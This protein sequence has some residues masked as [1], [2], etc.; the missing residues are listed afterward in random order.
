VTIGTATATANIAD[1]ETATADLSVT[2]QGNEAGPQ[3]IVYTVTLNAANNSGAP[4]TFAI[5][6][7]GGTATSG[8]DFTAFGGTISVANGSSTGTLTVT[9]LNDARLENTE[10]VQATISS[11]SLASVSIGAASA[12]AN[13]LEEGG[14]ATL[15]VTQNGVEATTPTSVV[16]TV[17]LSKTNNTGSAITFDV[18]NTAGGTAT[19]GVDYTAF[20]GAAAISVANG[21]STGTLTVTVLNDAVLEATETVI[22]TIS[23]AS[24]AGVSIAGASATASILDNETA[25]AALS[26]TQNGNEAGTVS[27]VYTVTLSRTNNS[28]APIT[29]AVS[30][31]GGTA[32]S[33]S[34]FTAF[35]GPAA[36]SVANGASTGTLTV[37]VTDDALLEPTE[38][39]EASISDPSLASVSITT[40]TATAN[41]L[42][43][44]DIATLSIP[45]AAEGTN[46]VATVSLTKQNVT[47][48]GISFSFARTGGTST[49]GVDH[50]AVPA[51]ITIA[52]GATSG[53]ANVSTVDDALL[54]NDETFSAQI[55]S[56]SNPKVTFGVGTDAA[57]ANILETGA[58]AALSATSPTEGTDIV[59]TVTLSKQNVTGSAV[60]FTFAKTGGTSAAADYGAVPATISV[61]NNQ[62][63]GT[64]NLTTNDDA[65]LEN[66]ETFDA[67]ISAPTN[68]DVT[69]TTGSDATTATIN[70][71][72]ATATLSASSPT[73]G[74]DIVFTVTLS[75]QNVTGS[76]VSF[77]LA[78][79]GTG[80]A[81]AADY[82]AVPA[83]VSV[84]DGASS[85][86]ANL[87][88]VDD[89]LL[90]LDETFDAQISAPSN[91]D[92]TFT[93]GSDQATATI[94][95]SG[96]TVEL[97]TQTD[98]A[99]N[100]NQS[101]VYRVELMHNGSAKTNVTGSAITVDYSDAT[102]AQGGTATVVLD[103]LAFTGTATIADGTGSTTFSVAVVDDVV[104]EAPTLETVFAQIANLS[105]PA[106]VS[107]GTA[108][109]S[110]TIASNE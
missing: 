2:Q 59:F 84:A 28:G 56:P 110:A 19:S 57:T 52:N 47:G 42:E 75:K 67:Q 68:G 92:V 27:I 35:D 100:P 7:S 74:S 15:S 86:T 41:I 16:Y 99:E 8:T 83:S 9:V 58:T 24:N 26:V 90:E 50:G 95:E 102:V 61:A 55:S 106:S 10:T 37:P 91:G 25:S 80:S 82:G 89:N 81:T 62:S 32:T 4:I 40:P 31:T 98:G 78:D 85:G 36:I 49:A 12:T 70:E 20:G 93:A 38:T 63:S 108:L 66:D 23:N 1:D 51:T 29:F 48:A 77:T 46:L 101:I 65:L 17:S 105:G 30:N 96:A 53:S 11:P 94:V 54:E 64:A 107:L 109:R 34:D 104:P 72:G 39:V 60:D 6:N 73:E 71:S 13:I 44:G 21:A 22:A 14:T 5:A 33:G 18:T 103:Y 43:S 97:V 76:A 45:D 69:F 3:N 88:T 87:T 79:A